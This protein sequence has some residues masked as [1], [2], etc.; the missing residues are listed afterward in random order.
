MKRLTENNRCTDFHVKEQGEGIPLLMI[1]GIIGDG[2]F[3]EKSAAYLMRTHRVITY[4][5]RGYGKNNA[6][7]YEDYSVAAQAEDAARILHSVSEIPVWIVGYSAGGLIAIELALRY[8]ELLQGMILLEPSLGYAP[9]EHE[10]LLAWNRELNDYLKEGRVKKALPA[11]SRMIGAG[12]SAGESASAPELRR[13]YQNLLAFMYGELNEVQ[14]YLP[15]IAQLRALN[16][17]VVIGITEQGSESIFA[18]SA[19]TAADLIG[20]P[21][22]RF[23]GFHNVA[24]EQPEAFAAKIN[25]II[26]SYR[27]ISHE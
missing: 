8:P 21:V 13:I 26:L 1:H 6:K 5:R 17:P 22:V 27:E 20:W 12:N 25:D 19:R 4:D 18:T 14:N 10:K 2:T 16:M 11:F 15:P 9:S 3:F 23:P 7:K 24:R